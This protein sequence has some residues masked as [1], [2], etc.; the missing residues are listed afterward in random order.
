[1]ESLSLELGDFLFPS[2]VCSLHHSCSLK[3]YF[4]KTWSSAL[5]HWEVV[6]PKEG[7]LGVFPPVGSTREGTVG[8]HGLLIL[9]SLTCLSQHAWASLR[10]RGSRHRLTCLK[11][12]NQ[13]SLVLFRDYLKN[14]NNDCILANTP[15]WQY[16][17]ML[18]LTA[19]IYF[20]SVFITAYDSII[21]RCDNLSHAF[22]WTLVCSYCFVAPL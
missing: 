17:A 16:A 9:P 12:R 3:F 13:G 18:I 1:M 4:V 20:I 22:S 8:L 14:W 7:T 21:W 2:V 5:H 19:I 11:I 15:S 10:V 6:E